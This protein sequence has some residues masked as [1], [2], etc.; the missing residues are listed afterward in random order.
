[1]PDL[2]NSEKT[3]GLNHISLWIGQHIPKRNARKIND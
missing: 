3:F 1:M 2:A